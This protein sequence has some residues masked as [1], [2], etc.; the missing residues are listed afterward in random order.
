MGPENIPGYDKVQHLAAC[1]VSLT[2]KT[3]LANSE[4][5]TI[6]RLWDSLSQFDKSRVTY[7]SR[8]Q[9]KAI[10]GRFA[11]SKSNVTPGVEIVKR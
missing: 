7:S 5:D 6:V 10:K 3:S 9:S 1:L 2:D 4:V 8:F 11:L